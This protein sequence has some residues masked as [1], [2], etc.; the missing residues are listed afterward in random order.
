[1]NV[2][3]RSLMFML[4]LSLT[5]APHLHAF[6]FDKNY[7]YYRDANVPPFQKSRE[8]FDMPNRPGFFEVTLVSDTVG[9][10]TFRIV[11][12]RDEME[13]TLTQKRTYS[14][15]NHEFQ[16]RFDNSSG[17]DDLIVEIANSNPAAVAKVSVFVVELP[18][19]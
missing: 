6:E 11:R 15:G 12:V 7:L 16:T 9:P 14:V 3:I 1:M 5:T 8:F 18:K 2:L 17:S 4:L 10:L 19:Q 13:K